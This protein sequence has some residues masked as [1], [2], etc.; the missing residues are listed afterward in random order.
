M[1]VVDSSALIAILFEEPENQA[2]RDAITGGERCVMS[3]VNVHETACVL[4]VRL[5]PPAVMKLWR[6]LQEAA[7][8]IA[9]FDEA[10]ARAAI[11]AY[12]RYGKGIHSK[13]R[14]NIADCAAY[15]LA[16]T[17]DAHLLFKGD[18][19]SQTDVNPIA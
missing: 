1:I 11:A 18:D 2:F 17:M 3:A 10:Q 7:I 6:L 8:E 12:D 16:K 5:G 4:R 9:P 14:L 13:A 19:F 15:A